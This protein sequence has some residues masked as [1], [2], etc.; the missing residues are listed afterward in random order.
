[1][2]GDWL[3]VGPN[4]TRFF[5]EP[6]GSRH[7]S[8][9]RAPNRIVSYPVSAQC[10][11]RT[12]TLVAFALA[13][14]TVVAMTAYASTPQAAAK[15]GRHSGAAVEASRRS[16]VQAQ[17]N[18][19]ARI[20]DARRARTIARA[21]RVHRPSDPPGVS[22]RVVSRSSRGRPTPGL[23]AVSSLLDV[24]SM[25]HVLESTGFDLPDVRIPAPSVDA[26]ET[27]F[28]AAIPIFTDEALPGCAP[29]AV[30]SPR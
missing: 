27:I 15:V 12:Q 17:A 18:T 11:L 1:M 21:T 4:A 29:P 30:S 3:M 10:T 19:T 14:T 28:A 16:A 20:P 2:P 8:L 22:G 6:R 5:T 24:L 23:P 26:A 13:F 7:R 9:H 25:E